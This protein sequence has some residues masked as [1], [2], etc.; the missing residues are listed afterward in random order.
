M[1]GVLNTD[2]VTA[3][4][5]EVNS[6]GQLL[7]SGSGGGGGNVTIVGPLGQS[8]AAAS[9]PV[10]L[11]V[12]Q[13]TAL[14]PP[15]AI[16]NYALETGGN[17]A[18]IFSGL[19]NGTQQTKITNGTT[20]ADVVVGDSGFSGLATAVASKQYSFTTSSSGAQNIGQWNV[21]GY[22]WVEINYTSVGSGL[23]LTGQFAPS[24]GGSYFNSSSFT[25]SP[26]S[27]PTSALGVVVNTT[28]SG[29]VRGNYFQLAVSALTSGTFSG[30]VTLRAINPTGV[31]SVGTPSVAQSGTWTVQ[32]GNTPNTTA[33]LTAGGKTNNN[34]APGATNL[35]ALVG[36]ANAAAPSWTEGNEVLLS[37]DLAG[38]LRVWNGT[39]PAST[40]LNTYSVHITTNATTTP[41]SATAYISS[42]TISNEV[43]GTTSS[44]TI[45]DKQ[46]TP[47]KLV[48]GLATTALTTAPTVINFQTPV[49]MVSGID[50]ITA[51]AVAATLDVWIN[52]YQ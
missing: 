38:N 40:A 49:K 41:T 30:T 9:V 50:V 2:G 44:I 10:V 6:S 18:N 12:A 23:A 25:S 51:G 48:N 52:Y 32:P 15:A 35:G 28:Y 22:S 11:P 7:T 17:L 8:L 13:I 47:L 29:S 27:T 3:T 16:T 14:T 21:E 34:A 37:T 31:I 36:V 45:Q 26:A 43:G 19:S 39:N 24:S 1:M 46:G 33:W 4:P 42:I 20:I 5:L